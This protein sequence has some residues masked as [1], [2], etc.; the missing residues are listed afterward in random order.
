MT[1]SILGIHWYTR[2]MVDLNKLWLMS[3]KEMKVVVASLPVRAVTALP[4]NSF[5]S[6][7][8]NWSLTDGGVLLGQMTGRGKMA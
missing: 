2:P 5:R 1:T 4:G 3:E 6:N 8:N 7:R